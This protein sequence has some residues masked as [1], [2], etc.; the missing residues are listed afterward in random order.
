MKRNMNKV[1]EFI[2]AHAHVALSV[3]A[4][5]CC[6]QFVL[7]LFTAIRSGNFGSDTIIQL[8]SYA[9][10]VETVVL[11]VIVVALKNKNK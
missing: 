1:K 4:V 7:G 10:G 2:K 3:P 8:L 11:F 5:L 6:V 9:D